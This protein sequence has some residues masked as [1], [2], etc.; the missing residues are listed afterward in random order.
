MKGAF[1]P[2]SHL[3]A[4]TSPAVLL[5]KLRPGWQ[6]K[7][8]LVVNSIN[9]DFNISNQTKEKQGSWHQV[10]GIVRFFF[11]CSTL[12]HSGY[13]LM[14]TGCF[15]SHWTLTSITTENVNELLIKTGL[16]FVF[17]VQLRRACRHYITTDCQCKRTIK[18]SVKRLP[19]SCCKQFGKIMNWCFFSSGDLESAYYFY[20]NNY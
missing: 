7:G 17:L 18:L 6:L 16:S 14:R 20:S 3:R 10:E 9:W 5:W 12:C 2:S 4:R 1:Y 11:I 19:D 15:F 8:Y 13:S